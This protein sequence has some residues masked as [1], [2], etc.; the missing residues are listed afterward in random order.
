MVQAKNDFSLAVAEMVNLAYR[1]QDPP[2][3]ALRRTL[4]E[5]LMELVDALVNENM[6][7]EWVPNLNL[8][9]VKKGLTN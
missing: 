2:R 5:E 9:D 8:N 6:K 3:T 1:L 7:N 4:E